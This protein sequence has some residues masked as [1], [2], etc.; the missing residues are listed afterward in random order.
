M[1]IDAPLLVHVFWCSRQ[2][3]LVHRVDT[4]AICR[5]LRPAL[6]DVMR[7]PSRNC[8]GRIRLATCRVVELVVRAV[9]LAFIVP[10]GIRFVSE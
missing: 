5:P 1:F 8:R 4:W 3:R 7:E 10:L 2:Y 9:R 6:R